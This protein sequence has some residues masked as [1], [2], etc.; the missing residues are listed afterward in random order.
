MCETVRDW[1]KYMYG[2]EIY[3]FQSYKDRNVL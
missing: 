2:K 3:L 1:M